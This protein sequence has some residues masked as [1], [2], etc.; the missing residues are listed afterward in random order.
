MTMGNDMSALFPDVLSCMSLP[1]LEIKKMVYLYL[2][3]YGKHKPDLTANAIG[4][5]TRDTADENPLIRALALRTMS[6]IPVEKVA[7]GLCEPLRRALADRDPYV[8]KTAA[9]C[10][11]KMFA[12]REE[13][14]RQH[15]FVEQ[16]GALLNH[17]NPS[18]VANAVA[19]LMDMSVRSP[20]VEF[21]LS[22]GQVNKLL[23]A[24][25]E[26]NEW[27]QTY[28]LE[29]IMTVVPDDPGDAELLADRISPRLQHSNSAVVLTAIRIMLYLTNYIRNEHAILAIFKKLGPPLVT[30]LHNS[31]EVQYVA[32]RNIQLILQRQR[33]FLQNDLKVFF[34]RYDDPIYVK[35]A[36]LDIMF[37]LTNESNIKFVLPE[38]K[39]YAAEVDVDFVRKA[40]RSIGRC[41]IKIESSADKCIEALVEL[42]TTKVNYVVQEAVVVIKDIFRKYP[43]RYESIIG[44]LCESLDSLDE[45]EAKASM[46]WIVGQYSDRIENADELLQQFLETFKDDAAEVQLALLTAIVKLFIKRPTVGQDLVPKVLKLATEE[47]DNPDLRDRGFIYWRL[48][49]TDPV[50][51]KAIIL[52]E[53]PQISIDSDSMDGPLLNQLL[54]HV[55]T[56]SSLTHRPPRMSD[57]LAGRIAGFPN[58]ILYANGPPVQSTSEPARPQVASSA[59]E[60]TY[61]DTSN[62]YGDEDLYAPR[63]NAAPVQENNLL[64][65]LDLTVED[66]SPH[67]TPMMHAGYYGSPNMGTLPQGALQQDSQPHTSMYSHAIGSSSSNGSTGPYGNLAGVS[68]GSQGP[69]ATSG[70]GVASGNLLGAAG[71]A[72]SLTS[73]HN[74]FGAPASF[75]AAAAG[76][77]G[78]L[79]LLG[80][81][82]DP[83][84][85]LASRPIG[86]G[87]GTGAG[88]GALG[89]GPGAGMPVGGQMAFGATPNLTSSGAGAV[90][91]PFAKTSTG[92]GL[93]T[94]TPLSSSTMSPMSPSREPSAHPAAAGVGEITQDL[95]SLSLQTGFATQKTLFLAAQMGRGLEIQ[96]AFVRR[97]GV[98]TCEMVL[99][100]RALQPLSDFA[101]LFNKNSFSLCPATPLEVRS[102]LFPN[103]SVETSL[104]L[105]VEGLPTTMTPVN[106]LQVAFKTNAGIVYFQTLVPLYLFFSEQGQL[107]PQ[108]WLKMWKEEIPNEA[109]F[110]FPLARVEPAAV[111]RAK[112]QASNV[113]TV[114]ERVVDNVPCM[115]L[116][117]KLEDGT[118]FLVEMRI[119]SSLSI[120]ACVVKTYAAHLFDVF[121]AS[122]QTILG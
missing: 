38:L 2:I 99:T 95:Y 84:P 69:D 1:A 100:N 114:A 45:P 118:I 12:Y 48:L 104:K 58:F 82:T 81:G 66:E 78:G 90:L 68:F 36:K 60:T 63:V 29:S 49:S 25:E 46:V 98:L 65:L 35:L 107:P 7:E 122:I 92:V 101:I 34:C 31:P 41:A 24:I 87:I 62:R 89:L 3:T 91:D 23:S 97:H 4:F 85:P 37:R 111:V 20:S 74:P 17:D 112:L 76:A 121:Q 57:A 88:A 102:P 67:G 70:L 5:L 93:G 106:N 73:A 79:D 14:V 13:L 77:A 116:S 96:G 94:A 18:V 22:I 109:K 75:G 50:A 21:H 105:K 83:V 32:L 61:R 55:S 80:L 39:E 119:E 9:L 47:I 16:L 11:A 43:N 59:P 30:L 19:A 71:G 33:D 108:T 54:Y 53:R 64:D 8:C 27:A 44:T 117:V 52:S 113:F 86:G 42:I 56:L 6:N 110:G 40:V 115:Y 15:G 26:C 72:P 28:I 51:A 120:C 103:Q 10:V